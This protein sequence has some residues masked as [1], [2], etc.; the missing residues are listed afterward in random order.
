MSTEH[1]G[2]LTR[3]YLLEKINDQMEM[4]QDKDN[5]IEAMHNR[6]TMRSIALECASNVQ[7]ENVTQSLQRADAYLAWLT[8]DG[9][10]E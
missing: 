2:D 9:E 1:N 4:I 7:G 8:N 3:Q 6:N 5:Y 10:T